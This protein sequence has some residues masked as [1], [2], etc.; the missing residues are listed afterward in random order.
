MLDSVHPA[1]VDFDLLPSLESPP[2]DHSLFLIACERL[3]DSRRRMLELVAQRPTDIEPPRI[4]A[5]WRERAPGTAVSRKDLAIELYRQHFEAACQLAFAEGRLNVEQMNVL[6]A[7]IDPPTEGLRLGDRT[8]YAEQLALQRA[9]NSRA[10]SGALV[11]TADMD[12]PVTQY[13]YLPAQQPAL[14]VFEQRSQMETWLQQYQHL[15]VVSTQHEQVLV[16]YTALTDS[17]LT[18]GVEQLIASPAVTLLS[19]APPAPLADSKEVEPLDETI[20]LFGLLNPDIPLSIRR[21]SLARQRTAI[22]ALFRDSLWN[23]T[24]DPRQLKFKQSLDALAAAEQASQ[25]AASR[26]LNARDGLRMLELRQKPNEHYSALYQARL[27]GLR[28][29]SD[30][31]LLLSQISTEEHGMLQAI[32]DHSDKTQRSAPVVV[33]SLTLTCLNHEGENTQLQSRE[34]EGVLLIAHPSLLIPSSAPQS[35]LL[36]WPGELGGLQRFASLSALERELFKITPND[37]ER[38]LQLSEQTSDPFEQGLQSQ[39][40]ACEQL[41]AKVIADNPVPARAQRRLAQMEKLREQTLTDLCVATHAARDQAYSQIIEQHHSG[42]LAQKRPQWLSTLT[43]A[44]RVRL[45]AMTQA[46]IAAMKRSQA[47]LERELPHRQDFIEKRMAARLRQDFSLERDFEIKLDLPDS[48]SWRK[49]VT[50]GAAP[51]TPQENILIPSKNRSTVSIAEF[52]LNNID[53]STWDRLGFMKVL[54]QADDPIERHI[55]QTGIK[56][57]YL[58]E[59]VPDLNLAQKYEDLIFSTFMGASTA[60]AFDNAYRREC[61]IE[62]W[63]LM[64]KLQGECALAQRQIN[65]KGRQILDIAIDADSRQAYAINGMNISLLP[66]SLTVG[67]AD[68]HQEGPAGLAGITFIHELNSGLT[69]LYLPDSPDGQLLRQYTSL[70]HARRSLF[71]LCQQ[72]SMVEYLAGRTLH[73]DFAR[74]VSRINQSV[75]R[76]FDALIGVG[77]AWPVT[78]SLAAHLL[79]THMGRL[80]EAH[81]STSRSNRKLALEHHAL[82]SGV[83]LNYLKMA[84]G[85]VPFVGSAIAL[86]DAWDSANLSVAAFLRGDVG[87]GLA[88]LESVLLSLIDAAMD[89]LPGGNAAPSAARSL[90]RQRQLSGLARKAGT[91]SP[92]T[93]RKALRTA[94]RFQGYEYEHDLSLSN[95]RPGSSGLYRNVYRHELGDFIVSQGRIYRVE[96]SGNPPFWRLSGSRSRSYKQPIALDEN[97]N[98]NTHFAVYGTLI[99]GGGLGGGG[100]LGHHLAEGLDPL[101]PA[102]IRRWLPRWWTDATFRHRLRL[103]NSVDADM[104]RLQTQRTEIEAE[105]IVYETKKPEARRALQPALERKYVDQIE[106]AESNFQELN[107]LLPLTSGENHTK[108]QKLRSFCAQT[109]FD[110]TLD[111][112]QFAFARIDWRLEEIS[113]LLKLTDATPA[114]ETRQ[115]LAL[116]QK[117]KD[118]RKLIMFEFE[119]RDLYIERLSVW[120]EKIPGKALKTDTTKVVQDLTSADRA[121]T[122]SYLKTAHAVRIINRYDVVSDESWFFFYVHHLK[123]RDHV[124]RALRTQSDLRSVVSN[125][126]QH[127]AILEDCLE[128]YAKFRRHLMAANTGYSEYMDA[129]QVAIFLGYLAEMEEYAR[130]AIKKRPAI[131]NTKSA[132]KLFKTEDDQWLMGKEV[133]ASET[134][135][136][137]FEVEGIEGPVERWLPHPDGKYRLYQPTVSSPETP[138]VINVKP[139]L[140]EA[141]NRLDSQDAYRSK[142]EA[143]ARQNMLPINLEHLM[144]SEAEQLRAR[145]ERIKAV[146]P[147]DPVITRL[148]DK[149]RELN[150]AGRAL[151]IKQTMNSQT[152]TQQYLDYLVEMGLKDQKLIE[153]RKVG[154]LKDLGRGTNRLRDYLQE[155]EVLDLTQPSPTPLWY[156][157]FHYNSAKSTFDDFVK[158]HLKL[159]QQRNLGLKW[160]QAQTDSGA[161]VESIWRGDIGKLLANKHFADL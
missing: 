160:Q 101:W 143:Y 153:I 17:P 43:D 58:R 118:I 123:A 76:H 44:Q 88:Q 83:M 21:L 56:Q 40:Y 55:L 33:F 61:L 41:A 106:L 25:S 30:I 142:V 113:D 64:L 39:L 92:T 154:D 60:P 13:L 127:N 28:A 86:Y 71:N 121:A 50:D 51:G 129:G 62:P 68:T 47:L 128:A 140:A 10:I 156:A 9:D 7:I 4:D 89:I 52:V 23:V 98:W 161:Q 67:G 137:H 147:Q 34:L 114:H 139:W 24:D 115:H 131:S 8:I 72:T 93:N 75:L 35:L 49:V 141:A 104:R 138:T 150:D 53:Q 65:A 100:V 79:N 14:T 27:A 48:T 12:Q 84:L 110:R 95:I 102:A 126:N 149:A 132:R 66:V 145:A 5:Y 108:V 16:H 120:K 155:Y 112:L 124:E 6:L 22:E 136:K 94:E 152:P 134:A 20:S 78:T 130:R 111:R 146:K 37:S 91:L 73:G 29:E 69:L 11:I 96:Q 97:G 42:V 32:L 77:L 125:V 46:F 135:P 3:D 87:N 81:R 2:T 103:V 82:A 90:T 74:H 19:G 99:E 116:L 109:I 144:T 54:V 36:Y 157:H 63:R 85:M 122:V 105:I 18:A 80:I 70:E 148:T 158:A 45:K 26:L 159:P 57:H 107:E 15:A 133:E 38:A 151:R 59:I 1:P 117:R 31:Q 119:Q